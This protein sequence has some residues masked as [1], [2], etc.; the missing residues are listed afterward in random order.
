[1]LFVKLV[2]PPSFSLPFHI[3]IPVLLNIVA[4]TY[5]F[6]NKHPLAKCFSLNEHLFLYHRHF[7]ILNNGHRFL[8][9]KT[10]NYNKEIAVYWHL[11][12]CFS[13][14]FQMFNCISII[15]FVI[16]CFAHSQTQV[17]IINII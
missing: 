17:E 6:R 10:G 2:L 1:M 3:Y 12:N 4:E 5:L 15:L 8:C 11:L 16:I 13:K 9:Q 14:L 7:G